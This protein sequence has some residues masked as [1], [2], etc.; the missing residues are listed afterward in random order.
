MTRP[1]ASDPPERVEAHPSAGGQPAPSSA[2]RYEWARPPGAV[3]VPARPPAPPETPQAVSRRRPAGR[4]P[5]GEAK[6]TRRVNLALSE[7][8]Y[9]QWSTAAGDRQL[10]TWARSVVTGHLAAERDRPGVAEE[11]AK[12]RAAMTRLGGNINQIARAL[13]AEAQGGP[14]V[15]RDEVAGDLARLRA[16]QD[17]V[18]ELLRR[19]VEGR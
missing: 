9:T 5:A 7:D 18:R 4:P 3:D 14:V 19:L 6:R 15:D 10:A 13:N 11:V 17:E 1:F 8:E 12:V 16:G 2:P